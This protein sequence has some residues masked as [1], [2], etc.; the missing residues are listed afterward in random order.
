MS[1]EISSQ[2]IDNPAIN[3]LISL[4]S[5][6]SRQTMQS[7]LNIVARFLGFS[8]L[9]TCP[10]HQL[11][12]QHIQAILKHLLDKNRSPSTINTYLAAIKGVVLE[13]WS[14]KLMD[15]ETFQ[16]I[17][18]I[19]SV[20]GSRVTKGRALSHDEIA[21]IFS[22]L[23]LDPSPKGIRD[24]AIMAVLIGCG[25]RRTELVTLDLEHI[26][27][28]E[29]L[30]IVS[31]KGNKQR[32]S[33]IPQSVWGRVMTWINDVRGEYGGALFTRIRRFDDVTL[34]RL[35]DQA[36]YHILKVRQQESGIAPFSPHDLRRTFASMMLD[37]G[38]D[39]V[40]V[41]DAMGHASIN[42]TQRYD[43]RG[44]ERLRKASQKLI[45]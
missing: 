38:E 37:N 16:R 43:R 26:E 11:K 3:Y 42:T 31:G 5:A 36:I 30:F 15:T 12:R 14:M 13:A 22:T 44:D 23:L 20:H 7:F 9:M 27:R 39:I 8:D 2:S 19:K 40:T 18:Q 1:R 29:Q 25:L 28:S 34:E 33:F 17:K 45:F 32:K 41:K 24:S 6:K 4:Q 35:T 10:W 21:K